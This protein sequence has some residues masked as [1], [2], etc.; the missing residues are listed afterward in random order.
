MR[1]AIEIVVLI[2][3]IGLIGLVLAQEG[4]DAGFGAALS[5][6]SD[7]YWGKNKGRSKEGMLVKATTVLLILLLVLCLLLSSQW[8]A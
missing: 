5:G 2:V 3:C 4:K 7:T 6:T 8:I 1:L